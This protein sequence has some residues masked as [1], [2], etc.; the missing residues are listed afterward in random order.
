MF[1]RVPV[2]LAVVYSLLMVLPVIV[3]AIP[4]QLEGQAVIKEAAAQ[5]H[6]DLQVRQPGCPYFAEGP[7]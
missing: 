3:N 2:S 4:V 5:E 1:K 6:V 7:N